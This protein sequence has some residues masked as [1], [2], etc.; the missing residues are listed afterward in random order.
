MSVGKS[1]SV[2]QTVFC[3]QILI[4]GEMRSGGGRYR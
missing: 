2:N 4:N 3:L 1:L